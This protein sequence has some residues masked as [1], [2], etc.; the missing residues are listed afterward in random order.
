MYVH[1]RVAL[2]HPPLV[3][4][5]GGMKTI[6]ADIDEL[7]DQLV[8]GSLIALAV[9]EDVIQRAID[10]RPAQ[11]GNNLSCL[12]E[13]NV[14]P[15]PTLVMGDLP[16]TDLRRISQGF[17]RQTGLQSVLFETHTQIPISRIHKL[18]P[19]Y[20]HSQYLSSLFVQYSGIRFAR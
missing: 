17:L 15:A 20:S 1:S 8:S 7:T 19:R 16:L 4:H 9:R 18:L 5:H 11:R 10:A 6:Y 12:P 14:V 3:R 13:G 2:P